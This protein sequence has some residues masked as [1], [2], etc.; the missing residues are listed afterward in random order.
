[1]SQTNTTAADRNAHY[2]KLNAR[3]DERAAVLMGLGFK[4]EHVSGLGIAVFLK[5][6]HTRPHAI[7]AGVVMNAD[8]VVWSDTLE[9][10]ERFSA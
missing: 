4:Y 3:F 6:R 1:M 10:A 8:D 5:T 9:S 7:T 2:G